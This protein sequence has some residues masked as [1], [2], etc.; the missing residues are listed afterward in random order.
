[1]TSDEHKFIFPRNILRRV[2]LLQELIA[3][4]LQISELP[5]LDCFFAVKYDNLW[6]YKAHQQ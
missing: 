5:R 2:D 6:Q 3:N 1:M 4:I